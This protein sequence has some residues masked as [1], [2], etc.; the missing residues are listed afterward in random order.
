MISIGNA[1]IVRTYYNNSSRLWYEVRRRSN[2]EDTWNNWTGIAGGGGGSR[3]SSTFFSRASCPGRLKSAAETTGS[4]TW[5]LIRKKSERTRLSA[6]HRV[7]RRPVRALASSAARVGRAFKTFSRLCR[8]CRADG[9]Q[10]SRDCR[11]FRLE[12]LC[13]VV[14]A[15]HWLLSKD[16]KN[17]NNNNCNYGQNTFRSR[18]FISY[19]YNH[20]LYVTSLVFRSDRVSVTLR[21]VSLSFSRVILPSPAA[22]D[23]CPAPWR[24]K[25]PKKN[26]GNAST[27]CY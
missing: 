16:N 21:S 4:I 18:R 19:F 1:V 27:G 26:E 5:Q 23:C 12:H 14:C 2:A 7:R 22:L 9:C 10:C 24:A 3:R 11:T 13:D 17:N 20:V 6:G 25:N 15:R 8:L